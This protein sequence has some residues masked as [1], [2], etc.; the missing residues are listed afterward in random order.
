MLEGVTTADRVVSPFLLA[1]PLPLPQLPAVVPPVVDAPSV[2]E[3]RLA[4]DAVARAAR[5]LDWRTSG[6]RF[7]LG[8]GGFV[9]S[10][11]GTFAL[12][13]GAVQGLTGH[14]VGDSLAWIAGATVASAAIPAGLNWL[15]ARVADASLGRKVRSQLAVAEEAHGASGGVGRAWLELRAARAL[16]PLK[17]PVEPF[18]AL[19]APPIAAQATGRRLA[20]FSTSASDVSAEDR[21]HAAKLDQVFEIVR[22][23]ADG[24][25]A[26]QLEA[27]LALVEG[28]PP[29][30]LA[31]IRDQ[32]SAPAAE[33]LRDP[34]NTWRRA[35]FLQ[36]LEGK[37]KPYSDKGVDLV[38]GP[39]TAEDLEAVR[40]VQ[41]GKV[42]T[43]A[44]TAARDIAARLVMFGAPARVAVTDGLLA[45][46]V[47]AHFE[48]KNYRAALYQRKADVLVTVYAIAAPPSGDFV[49][50]GP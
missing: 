49:A 40:K 5:D 10:G 27:I 7:T 36:A 21:S 11:L 39:P 9:A 6:V 45:T 33:H 35:R 32:L 26:G 41:K 38:E 2:E 18:K 3:G 25:L 47:A 8:L 15:I 44:S 4:L 43:D 1:Q 20:A 22:T 14:A 37:V 23:R 12:L 30:A 16:R 34:A 17:D 19:F 46:E 24:Y 48:R 13:V 31:L 42:F 29:E 50:G 28:L